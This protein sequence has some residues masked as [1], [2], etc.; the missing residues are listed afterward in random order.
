[1][2]KYLFAYLNVSLKFCLTI[3]SHSSAIADSDFL[4]GNWAKVAIIILEGKK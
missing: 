2:Y 1:M 4:L 3:I